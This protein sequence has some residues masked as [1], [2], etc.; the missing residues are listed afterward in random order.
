MSGSVERRYARALYE[1]ASEAKVVDD[2]LQG[3]SNLNLAF[4]TVPELRS[5][6]LNPLVP[7][8]DKQHLIKTVTSN[9][10]VLRFAQLLTERKRLDLLPGIFEQFS[11]LVDAAHG[12]RRALVR[13]A[14]PLSEDQRRAVEA[15]LAK[16][17]GGK[18]IGRF[19]VVR[20]LIGGVWMRVG[21]NVLDASLKGRVE[22]F[23]H[24]LLH[25]AN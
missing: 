5:V 20:D 17:V 10:L 15:S 11:Q 19:E 1:L 22:D 3:L 16:A 14:V 4:G 9:K 6:L 8:A 12:V 2:V 25:S 23:R 18:V 7:E 24:A 13:S 21:D